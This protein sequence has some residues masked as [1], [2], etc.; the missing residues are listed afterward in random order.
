MAGGA[1]SMV[2]KDEDCFKEA[3]IIL[4]LRYAKIWDV[5]SPGG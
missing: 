2:Q 5:K 4:L 3:P 1:V